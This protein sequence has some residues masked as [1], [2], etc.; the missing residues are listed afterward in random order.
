MCSLRF[1]VCF[2]LKPVFS[3]RFIFWGDAKPMF[4][5]RFVYKT[6]GLQRILGTVEEVTGNK[7]QRWVQSPVFEWVSASVIVANVLVMT[8]ELQ[9]NGVIMGHALNVPTYTETAQDQ[10]SL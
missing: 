9:Y 3:Y 2:S 5:N 8:I 6:K 1:I 4:S 7:L 10:R